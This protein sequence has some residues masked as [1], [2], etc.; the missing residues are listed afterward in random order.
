MFP[1]RWLLVALLGAAC[2]GPPER[3]APAAAFD[4]IVGKVDQ[5][6][7]LIGT[8]A[9][10]LDGV[11]W[12]DG[13][14]HPLAADRGKVVLVRWWTDTC[15]LCR[16]SA[17][18][19]QALQSKYG[20]R[21]DVR[22]VYHNKVP[23]RTVTQA[24]V[25]SLG[26]KLGFPPLIGHDRNWSAL[27]RWWTGGARR[28]YTSVTFLLGKQGRIRLI[29]TGGEFH[30]EQQA[31]KDACLYDP[32]QCAAEFAAIDEAIAVLSAEG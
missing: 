7:E 2:G 32:Q 4:P 11:Q 22:A 1:R 12:V 24:W 29:H 3:A 5:G 26:G 9:P 28:R 15:P 10:S 16:N 17:P 27:K 14:D 18:A 6:R 30:T 23:D 21:L 25:Q 31:G 8:P 19:V 20:D 13:G